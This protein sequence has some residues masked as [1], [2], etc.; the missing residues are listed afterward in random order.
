[1][2][3]W[4]EIYRERMTESYRNH[5]ATKY[6]HFLTALYE[7]NATI[8]TEIGCGAGNITRLLREMVGQKLTAHNMVD[9]CPKMLGMAVENNPSSNCNFKCADIRDIIMPRADVVH[10]HGLLEHFKDSDIC[11]I[12]G[13]GFEAAPLQIHYVPSV[14]YKT[15]SRGDERLMSPKQWRQILSD[16]GYATDVQQFNN[17]LD[18]IIRIGKR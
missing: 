16:F 15:P 6:A 3:P 8:Y 18:L 12:V 5:V 7:T 11:E 14:E 2:K 10:S 13:L 4:H 1:M 9:A 17:G